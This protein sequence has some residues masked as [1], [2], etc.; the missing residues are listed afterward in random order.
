MGRASAHRSDKESGS[1]KRVLQQFVFPVGI[2]KHQRKRRRRVVIDEGLPWRA[3]NSK[4]KGELGM[5]YRD[6]RIGVRE[7]F[8]Q[9]IESGRIPR[10]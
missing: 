9:L 10:Q 2:M 3:D 6:V 8:Q 7:M 4:G 1:G 5:T